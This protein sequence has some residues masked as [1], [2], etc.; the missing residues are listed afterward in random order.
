VKL[1]E[2]LNKRWPGAPNT[3]AQWCNDTMGVNTVADIPE[4]RVPEALRKAIG[5]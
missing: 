3:I 5:K 4:D 2:A 1:L